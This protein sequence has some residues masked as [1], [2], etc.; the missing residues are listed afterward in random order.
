MIRVKKAEN[1][2]KGEARENLEEGHKVMDEYSH[3][4]KYEKSQTTYTAPSA[5]NGEWGNIHYS[6]PQKIM[7]NYVKA[8]EN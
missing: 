4:M 1:A 3:A 2:W 7:D 8:A 5:A 6:N